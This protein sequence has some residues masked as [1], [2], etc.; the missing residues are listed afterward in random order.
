MSDDL[1]VRCRA[2]QLRLRDS[3]SRSEEFAAEFNIGCACQYVSISVHSPGVVQDDEM[4]ARFVLEPKHL[5]DGCIEVGAL[6]DINGNGLSLQRQRPSDGARLRMQGDKLMSD[7]NERARRRA[8]ATGS[9]LPAPQ[10]FVGVVEIVTGRV[11]RHRVEGAPP[12][13]VM[14]SAEADDPLHADITVGGACSKPLR[15]KLRNELRG[16]ILDLQP[17]LPQ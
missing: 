12:F 14:D 8:E 17:R 5:K 15:S 7:Q 10:T 2:C 11:R 3:E 16:L 4:L 9:P 6:R 1:E 13:C